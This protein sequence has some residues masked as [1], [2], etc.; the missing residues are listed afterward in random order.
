[1]VDFSTQLVSSFWEWVKQDINNWPRALT[2]P[3]GFLASL[4]LDKDESFTHRSVSKTTFLL[5]P[6]AIGDITAA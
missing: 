4:D 6:A 1:M 3:V 5:Y 2:N